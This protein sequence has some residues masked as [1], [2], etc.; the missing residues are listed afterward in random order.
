MGEPAPLGKARAAGAAP[1][2]RP[3]GIF[4]RILL[5]A[6]ILPYHIGLGWLLGQRFLMLTHTGR[7]TGTRRR[8]VVEVI[9]REPGAG[10]YYVASGW[11]ETSQWFRNVLA[12]PRV[13]ITVGRRSFAA[14]AER[15]SAERAEDVLRE[16]KQRHRTA[17]RA[18]GRIFGSQDPHELA[19]AVPVLAFRRVKARL[20]ETG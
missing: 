8:T 13:G 6:P 17:A 4:L 10:V 9:H 15:L 14:R 11:G 12:N 16:Y 2:R 5:R 18:L 20:G 1:I 3:P 7:K 19:Q